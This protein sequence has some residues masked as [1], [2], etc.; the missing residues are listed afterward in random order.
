MALLDEVADGE[1]V[2]GGVS[3]GETLISHV[4][5]REELLLLDEVR[6]FLPLG[7]GGVYTGGVVGAG[8]QEDNSTLGSVLR[9]KVG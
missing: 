7:R 2:V 3:G 5:E 6:D 8:M 9:V 1:R 4:E